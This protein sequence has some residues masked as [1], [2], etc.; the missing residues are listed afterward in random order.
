[1]SSLNEISVPHIKTEALTDKREEIDDYRGLIQ[2]I[3]T[4][5]SRFNNVELLRFS[6]VGWGSERGTR[7]PKNKTELDK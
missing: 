6:L 7:Q 1:M 2:P 5:P 4:Q 3:Q